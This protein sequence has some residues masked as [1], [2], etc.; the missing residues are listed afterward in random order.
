MRLGFVYFRAP[1][2]KFLYFLFVSMLFAM[3]SC[4]KDDILRDADAKVAFSTDTLTFDTVFTTLGSATRSFK[5]YNNNSQAIEISN[6]RLAG[7]FSEQFRINVDGYPGPDVSNVEI[8]AND[9]AWVF[10]EVTVDPVNDVN[11][12]V[13]YTDILFETNGN[14]QTVVLEAWGQDAYYYYPTEFLIEGF[15][16]FSY[17]SSYDNY[18]PISQ[19]VFLPNDKPH[20]IFN[21]LLIDSLVTLHIQEG[22]E[23]YLSDGGGLWAYRE[24]AIEAL[25]TAGNP[26]TFQGLRLESYYDDIPGQWDRIWINESSKDS[27]FEHCIIR[28]GFVGIQ[29]EPWIIYDAP[30]AIGTN[31]LYLENTIIENMDGLGILSRNYNI[32]AKNT[33]INNGKEYLL[34]ALGG[35]TQ[36]YVHCTFGNYFSAGTRSNPS[37]LLSNAYQDGYGNLIVGDFNFYAGNTIIDGNTVEEIETDSLLD[38]DFNY[39]FDRCI[40]KTERYERNGPRTQ[41]CI[42]NPAQVA[43][44]INPLFKDPSGF[45]FAL[46]SEA[47]AIDSGY[48]SISGNI[49]TDI[50]ENPRDG[51]PDIGAY[52]FQ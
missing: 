3:T 19:D 17:L 49:S 21:Y 15:P 30:P 24:S 26:V 27:R 29:A 28:N 8:Q 42:L 51:L 35:G 4:N 1:M 16:P 2:K 5:I 45:D 22:T 32:D 36:S 7:E 44:Y 37:L 13:L 12:L 25:G 11:P 31:T 50:E 34:A 43:G 46:H 40:L 9:S 23:I 39:L 41:N 33:L 10:V 18:F 14:T 20:V 47:I 38:A 48:N 6:I 52:E